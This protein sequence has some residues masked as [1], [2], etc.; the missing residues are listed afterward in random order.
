M[1]LTVAFDV[2]EGL[3]PSAHFACPP[4]R[5]TLFGGMIKVRNT[6]ADFQEGIMSFCD[7]FITFDANIGKK[8]LK[9]T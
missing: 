7:A 2:C 4:R 8:A 5:K 3:N 1:I 9:Y 6:S